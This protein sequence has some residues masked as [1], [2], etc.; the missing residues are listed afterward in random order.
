MWAI[1]YICVFIFSLILSLVLTK[2]MQQVALKKGF[3]DYPHHHKAHSTPVPLLGG[4]SIFCSFFITIFA[5]V[6]IAI[7]AKNINFISQFIP[8]GL[9][10]YLPGVFKVMYKISA[11]F[12]GSLI[13]FL[14]G[15]VDDSKSLGALVK[16]LVQIFAGTI[17]FLF[18]LKITLFTSNYIINYL[19]TITWIVLITNA[20]NLLDNMDGLAGGVACVTGAI[21]FLVSAF[22]QQYFVSL[23]LATFIGSIAGFLYFNFYPAKIFMGDAGSM[24]IGFIMAIGTLLG[25]YYYPGLPTIFAVAMPLLILAVP[26]YDTISVILIRIKT[27]KPI[28]Q[29][30]RNHFS[31]RLVNFGLSK[32]GAVFFICLVTLATG[33][34]ALL[35]QMVEW[36]GVLIILIQVFIF[37]SIVGILEYYGKKKTR[38]EEK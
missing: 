38:T 17:V 22:N 30:D 29:G 35:L 7:L 32:P 11:I 28:Y 5:G 19:F 2:I 12:A 9:I 1:V 33:I 27:H 21:F 10:E 31:H 8:Q 26:I 34:S 20:F 13:I 15:M 3:V 37:L 18:G 6:L 24:V 36:Q 4:A 14:L 16:L 23:L 25:T